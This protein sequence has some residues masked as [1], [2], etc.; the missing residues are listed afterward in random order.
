MFGSLS[1]SA[2]ILGPQAWQE[3]DEFEAVFLRVSL[4]L[5]SCGLS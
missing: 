4:L 1:L 3:S 2:R 5:A